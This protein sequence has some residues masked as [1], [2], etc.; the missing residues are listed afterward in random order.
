[1]EVATAHHVARN[2]QGSRG[3]CVSTSHVSAESPMVEHLGMTQGLPV[4]EKK[5]DNIENI[6]EA[7]VLRRNVATTVAVPCD[8]LEGW[9]G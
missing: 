6:E 5:S 9:Q 7:E 2:D 3:N 4:H 8:Q 1:M